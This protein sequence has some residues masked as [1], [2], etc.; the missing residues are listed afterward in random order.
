[1]RWILILLLFSSCA[2]NK[3]LVYDQPL[4]PVEPLQTKP[5]K[6]V[7]LNAY[8]V[9]IERYR[10]GKEKLFFDAID[11]MLHTAGMRI[12]QVADVPYELMQ[13]H[14]R[15]NHNN[16]DAID[17]LLKNHG[18]SHALIVTE[19][20]AKFEQVFVNVEKTQ[21]GKSREAFYDFLAMSEFKLFDTLGLIDEARMDYRGE[22][23]SRPVV[24]GLLAAGPSI[25]SNANSKLLFR[26]SDQQAIGFL[27]KFFPSLVPRKRTLFTTKVFKPVGQAIDANDFDKAFVLSYQLSKTDKKMQRAQAL[28]NCAILMERKG[29]TVQMEA[30]LKEDD[31]AKR[32]FNSMTAGSY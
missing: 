10:D 8:D 16:D 12:Q 13:G 9:A 5:S 17:T 4:Q 3:V 18:A 22:H 14:T 6:V 28:Y 15:I 29:D 32:L 21:S 19:F 1:M 26:V 2:A 23:S 24:S 11:S 25:T 27:N 7:L 31:M 20:N 30:M